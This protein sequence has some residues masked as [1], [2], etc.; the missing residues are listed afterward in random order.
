MSTPNDPG[1][2]KSTPRLHELL[3]VE[4]DLS[5]TA[6]KVVKEAIVTFTKKANHFV[7]HHKWL[8][9]FSD[10]R[11]QEAEGASE[12]KEIVE[13]V[14]SKLRYVSKAL[15]KYW[16]AI[17][18]KE[19]TNQTAVADLVVDGKVM[20]ESL[21]A[22]FLL[23]MESRLQKLRAVLSAIPT[24]EPGIDW[25]PDADR[26][27]D[28]FKSA[29]TQ[30]TRREEKFLA[31]KILVEPTKEHPAQ[32]EKWTEN[33]AVGTYHLQKWTST[34]SPAGKS[35]LLA[36]CDKLIRATK[37]ARQRANQATVVKTKVAKNMIDYVLSRD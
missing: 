23:G 21:P 14:P 9:M 12:T 22:T 16:D 11:Q 8:V 34:L 30:K 3:A 31:H 20:A 4:S 18:Q 10:E 17:C 19:A 36:R 5:N 32:I 28:V 26:G 37:K 15:V 27:E 35:D 13:T 7:G 29:D 6:E 1:T 33:R 24:H 25:V 2:R